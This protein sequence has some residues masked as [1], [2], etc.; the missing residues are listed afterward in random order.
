MLL[1]DLKECG[2]S[3]SNYSQKYATEGSTHSS[4]RIDYSMMIGSTDI[5]EAKLSRKEKEN[6]KEKEGGQNYLRPARRSI[7]TLPKTYTVISV[8][9][10]TKLLIYI[11]HHIISYHITN[12]NI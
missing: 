7:Y 3:L 1:N 4:P 8:R 5:G 10:L 2:N 6:E 9:K 12:D 11:A